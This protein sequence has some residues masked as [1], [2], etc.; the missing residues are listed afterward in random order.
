MKML[1]KFLVAA[2]NKKHCHKNVSQVFKYLNLVHV[3]IILKMKP[4]TQHKYLFLKCI[5]VVNSSIEFVLIKNFDNLSAQKYMQCKRPYLYNS[6]CLRFK[7]NFYCSTRQ[8]W[9]MRKLAREQST[10][11]III[12]V[13][14][15]PNKHVCI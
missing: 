10:S 9:N 14:I 15:K 6:Y 2:T 1:K 11:F 4:S 8:T 7:K 13:A 3:H 12:P 5:S